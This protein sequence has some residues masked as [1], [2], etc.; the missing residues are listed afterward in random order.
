MCPPCQSAWF[1]RGL[2]VLRK[3][4]CPSLRAIGKGH[5]GYPRQGRLFP[6]NQ[7][8]T[9]S[10][11]RHLCASSGLLLQSY[12]RQQV[13]N[14]LDGHDR[15]VLC[16][17]RDRNS[18]GTKRLGIFP[19]EAERLNATAFS[20]PFWIEQTAGTFSTSEF[21]SASLSTSDR[22]CL[23]AILSVGDSCSSIWPQSTSLR[24]R[25]LP[26]V[27]TYRYR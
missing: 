14:D 18:L 5:C 3:R 6:V 11:Y 19:F 25:A 1:S 17:I 21:L 26:I 27:V 20:K 8:V 15:N 23:T 9:A 16:N 24:T 4:H 22:N 13:K 12:P 7:A 10:Q 2:T